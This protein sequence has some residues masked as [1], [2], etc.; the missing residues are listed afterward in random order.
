MARL[1]IV[2][3]ESRFQALL[4]SM[5]VLIG[6]RSWAHLLGSGRWCVQVRSDSKA[7]LGA[8]MNLRSRNPTMNDVVRELAI[9]LAE[10]S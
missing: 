10:G 3:G 7:A 4:E 1:G 6:I 5:A 2:V 8:A 9:D